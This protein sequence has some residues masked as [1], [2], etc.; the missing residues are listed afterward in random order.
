MTIATRIA[1]ISA[2]IAF[3][4]I[5]PVRADDNQIC[6]SVGTKE[7]ESDDYY[8]KGLAACN[9][10]LNSGRYSGARLGPVYRQRGD[11]KR[12]KG[13]L[14]GAIADL[15]KAVEANRKDHE[16][17]AY[18]AVVWIEKKNDASALDD[19]EQALRLKPTFAAAYL[20]R[21]DIYRNRGS[22]DLAIAEYKKAIAQPTTDRIASWAQNTARARLKEIAE[23]DDQK[24]DR[25]AK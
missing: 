3:F 21:G 19:L 10:M 7:Y 15:D 11:W 5:S 1:C 17:F 4:A 2:S 18:R 14:D 8:D 16:S 20:D 6:F 13:D 24:I 9:R 12:R 22:V 25:K 23:T